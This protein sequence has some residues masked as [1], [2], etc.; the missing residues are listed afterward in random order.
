MFGKKRASTPI[1]IKNIF[2]KE[3]LSRKE[4]MYYNELLTNAQQQLLNRENDIG[5]LKK[6]LQQRKEQLP[7]GEQQTAE[8]EEKRTL[9]KENCAERFEK[10][11]ETLSLE[12]KKQRGRKRFH[13]WA[14][15]ILLIAMI[16][17]A[18]CYYFQV[19]EPAIQGAKTAY[20]E[21]K[22]EH[23]ADLEIK[24]QEKEKEL[25]AELK[26]LQ[27]RL[28]AKQEERNTDAELEALQK[29]LDTML[30]QQQQIWDSDIVALEEQMRQL[31]EK[32]STAD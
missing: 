16:A 12:L 27:E 7:F 26:A 18:V 24:L 20:E 28:E 19:D 23:I 6:E 13:R 10:E 25:D 22:K 2:I 3:K 5:R 14:G 21:S 1:D 17:G 31:Q 15:N 9:E 29:E 11:S 32:N 30:E 8:Y 4:R